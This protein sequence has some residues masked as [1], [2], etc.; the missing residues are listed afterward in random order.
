MYTYSGRK[1]L[2]LIIISV[3]DFCNPRK[4]WKTIIYFL[5][6]KFENVCITSLLFNYIGN[7][8]TYGKDALIRKCM[9]FFPPETFLQNIFSS[10]NIVGV[11]FEIRADTVSKNRTEL[12]G[13]RFKASFS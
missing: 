1:K 13:S 8:K 12:S 10:I 4:F 9:Q 6:W 7:R 2:R 11:V 3:I 5:I